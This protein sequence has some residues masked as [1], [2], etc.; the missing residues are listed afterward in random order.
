[1]RQGDGTPSFLGM[2]KTGAPTLSLAAAHAA[3]AK[4]VSSSV[5]ASQ[6]CVFTGEIV[7]ALREQNEFDMT[8]R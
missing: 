3:G 7:A 8:G 1:M 6:S 4:V 2:R 5:L